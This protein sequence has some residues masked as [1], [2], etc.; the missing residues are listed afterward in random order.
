[1]YLLAGW[2][3]KH[4]HTDSKGG[5]AYNRILF[6]NMDFWPHKVSY[7]V[8][9]WDQKS[10][11]KIVAAWPFDRY[12]DEVRMLEK[13]I[14]LG[15]SLNPADDHHALIRWVLD[16]RCPDTLPLPWDNALLK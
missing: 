5:V 9:E 2:V 4:L 6:G 8:S 1:M 15:Y 14:Y 16:F 7:G 3:G 12:P 11:I 10:V 13:D